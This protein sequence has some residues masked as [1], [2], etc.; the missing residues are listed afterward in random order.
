MSAPI[1][2]TSGGGFTSSVTVASPPRQ[3][4]GTLLTAWVSANWDVA[5]TPPAGWTLI[6]GGTINGGSAGFWCYQKLTAAIEPN[7][8]VWQFT[9][10][11][12][13]FVVIESRAPGW[14]IVDS[15]FASATDATTLN[16]PTLTAQNDDVLALGGFSWVETSKS[17]PAGVDVTAN[18]PRGIITGWQEQS[19]GTTPAHT[20]TAA[21]AGHMGAISLLLRM[22]DDPTIY[23][24][25]DSTPADLSQVEPGARVELVASANVGGVAWSWDSSDEDVELHTSGDTCV[26]MAPTRCEASTLQVTATASLAGWNDGEASATV[27]TQIHQHWGATPSGDLVPVRPR[28]IHAFPRY[29][30]ACIVPWELDAGFDTAES[31]A[32][33]VIR[34]ANL[35]WY[36]LT[37]ST[38]GSIELIEDITEQHFQRVRDLQ[39]LGVK[40]MMLV[41]NHIDTGG[42]FEWNRDHLMAVLGDPESRAAHIDA[43]ISEA[44]FRGFDGIEIDYENLEGDE[45]DNDTLV[46]FLRELAPR[47]KAHNLRLEIATS[48]RESDEGP[49][50]ADRAFDYDRIWPLV[51]SIR[52]MTY[53]YSGDWSEP[54]PLGPRPWVAQGVQYA[55][56][57]G[58]PPN[59]IAIGLAFWAVDWNT[60]AGTAESLLWT[61]VDALIDTY[62]PDIEWHPAY[63][64][65]HFTYTDGNG[66]DHE[67]W[68]ASPE[69]VAD[70]CELA[71]LY[72]LGGVYG[73][74]QGGENPA[75]YPAIK[76]GFIDATPPHDSGDIW[77]VGSTMH[78]E[79]EETTPLPTPFGVEEGDLMILVLAANWDEGHTLDEPGWTLVSETLGSVADAT[80]RIYARTATDSEPASYGVTWSSEQWHSGALHVWRNVDTVSGPVD[81]ED[82]TGTATLA[83]MPVSEGDVVFL[84]GSSVDS[85]EREFSPEPDEV[86]EDGGRGVYTASDWMDAAGSSPTYE[87]GITESSDLAVLA[88]AIVLHP[89]TS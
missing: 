47:A 73:W 74:H 60:T 24:T 79:S 6:D 37:T 76:S 45:G 9:E 83:T 14:A 7:Q 25:I 2:V 30:S 51:D 88:A 27:H 69:S 53:E 33:D 52:I 75:F 85:G 49:E 18:L 21:A 59:R 41:H 42:G 80:L 62:N 4:A 10:N 17:Y 89:V 11:Q 22:V 81:D 87:F 34:T 65:H 82:A 19:A 72:D 70:R 5:L 77:H 13:H 32:G 29:L 38:D 44:L 78:L 20:L 12:W 54:G 67:V 43:I 61:D 58:V 50:N 71:N 57:K 35:W 26:L 66:D 64:E 56:S 68:F 36:R 16:H 8:Y 23:V 63:R 1:G 84:A 3:G 31:L 15:D 48:N 46:T 28:H 55:L 39:A 40:V 86:Y